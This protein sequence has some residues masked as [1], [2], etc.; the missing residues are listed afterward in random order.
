MA[1]VAHF[2]DVTAILTC[3]WY[4]FSSLFYTLP[5]KRKARCPSWVGKHNEAFHQEVYAG[6]DRN[7]WIPAAS[8]TGGLWPG[9][10]WKIRINGVQFPLGTVQPVPPVPSALS[11]R[12]APHWKVVTQGKLIWD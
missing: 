11:S 4:L 1:S 12:A 2:T 9:Q 5:V 10:H 7:T 3:I 8:Y 6:K